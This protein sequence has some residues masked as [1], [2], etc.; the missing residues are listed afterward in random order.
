[1]GFTSPRLV[2]FPRK[3]DLPKHEPGAGH[4]IRPKGLLQTLTNRALRFAAVALTALLLCLVWDASQSA[5]AQLQRATPQ[6]R[7][8]PL[9]APTG[10][11]AQSAPLA[12]PEGIPVSAVPGS[13]QAEVEQA[14]TPLGLFLRA[15]IVVRCVL[16]LLVLASFWSW[17]LIIDKMIA[18][19][20]LNRKAK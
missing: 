11:P 1:D 15:D 13:A 14:F 16:S 19:G 12:A 9:A 18:F 2:K 4:K 8:P 6:N 7:R 10:A 5:Q 17:V 3:Q 20:S